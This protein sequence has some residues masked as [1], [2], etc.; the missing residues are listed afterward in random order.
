MLQLSLQKIGAWPR[1]GHA[2]MEANPQ[3]F[4]HQPGGPGT[5][6]CTGKLR[7]RSPELR[8]GLSL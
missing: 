1:L 2:E 8:S 5:R 4:K 7:R 6:P 3:A